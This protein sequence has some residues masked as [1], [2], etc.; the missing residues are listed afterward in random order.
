MAA[1]FCRQTSIALC[2]TTLL[3]FTKWHTTALTKWAFGCEHKV[4]FKNREQNMGTGPT[5]ACWLVYR[6]R[7]ATTYDC[8]WWRCRELNPGAKEVSLYVYNHSSL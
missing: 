3:I 5:L 8:V 2:T 4:E 1:I 7:A 6:E